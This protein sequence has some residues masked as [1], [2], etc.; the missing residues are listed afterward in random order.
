MVDVGRY[1]LYCCTEKERH[2][3]CNKCKGRQPDSHP[4]YL[5]PGT[6]LE[7]KYLIGRVLGHGGFGITYLGLD[8]Y[9]NM[10]VAIKEHLPS[11]LALRGTDTLSVIPQSDKA[12]DDFYYG[13]EKFVEEGRALAR[14]AD[15]PNIVTVHNFFHANGTAYLVMGYLEGMSMAAYM[16]SKGGSLPED[17][18]L[19]IATMALD[20]LRAIHSFGLLHRDIK[21]GN[22]FITNQGRAILIDFGSA[23]NSMGRNSRDI[24]KI[25]SEGYSP[26]ELYS[27]NAREHSSADIYS[28]GATMY[29]AISGQMPLTS[30]QQKDGASL[31]PLMYLTNVFV[32]PKTSSLVE[33]AMSIDPGR[34]FQ[35]ASAMINAMMAYDSRY[36]T[37]SV[38]PVKDIRDI[39]SQPVSPLHE[40]SGEHSSDHY[41]DNRNSSDVIANNGYIVAFPM[42][43]GHLSGIQLPADMFVKGLFKNNLIINLMLAAIFFAL[44]AIVFVL[45]PGALFLAPVFLFVLPMVWLV[46]RETNKSTLRIPTSPLGIISIL[47]LA[48]LLLIWTVYC[49]YSLLS[50]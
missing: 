49:F 22:I 8:L 48:L 33:T 23:R 11:N 44:I 38:P 37:T 50:L 13:M 47:F 6:I 12:G 40:I 36:Q 27:L 41:I 29:H 26:F 34:R 10:R 5:R 32:S 20:G 3:Q 24:S 1:C 28:V 18:T 14:F 43:G 16:K 46:W 39:Q 30:P 25:V 9:L 17:E 19:Q 42:D 4:L 35:N 45:L 15:N 31:A 7:N 21:P 2:G